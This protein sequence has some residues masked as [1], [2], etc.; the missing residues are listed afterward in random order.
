MIENEK[1]KPSRVNYSRAMYIIFSI[2][3]IVLAG[4]KDFTQAFTL[5]GLALIFDPFDQTIPFDKRPRYQQWW[6]YAHVLV[7]LTGLGLLAWWR[8]G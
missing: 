8:W 3:A 2:I 4:F 5:W 6:L 7:A 1:A